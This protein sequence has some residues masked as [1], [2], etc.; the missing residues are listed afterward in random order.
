MHAM[1]PVSDTAPA[2]ALIEAPALAGASLSLVLGALGK[3]DAHCMPSNLTTASQS[4]VS[5]GVITHV[6]ACAD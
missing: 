2:D 6:L 3:I 4:C 5:F 1:P